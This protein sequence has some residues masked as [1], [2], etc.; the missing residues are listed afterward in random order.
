[1]A[2]SNEES[3]RVLDGK[4]AVV[5]GAAVGIGLAMAK[6]LGKAG[7]SVLIND[8]DEQAT[9]AAIDVLSADGIACTAVTGDASDLNTIDQMVAMAVSEFGRLDIAIANAGISP[10]GGF[11]DYGLDAFR[12]LNAVNLESTFFLAQR[13]TRQMIDQGEGGRIL[14]MSSVTGYQYHPDCTAYAM[15]KAGIRMLVK[16][17]G[18]ELAPHGIRVNG[19]APGAIAVDRTLEDP[20]Y[21]ATWDRITPT[22][23]T[24]NPEDIASAAMFLVSPAAEH[25]TGQTLVV[26][27]GW[28]SLSPRP[29]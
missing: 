22:G 15:T 8:I 2:T 13:A 14:M 16:N 28:T 11:L 26:D 19:I 3:K 23:R 10:F 25:I 1:M 18:V 9:L 6:R 12:R 5:T 7:A 29:D 20:D 21:Q 17:L 4:A 27:G 24:G